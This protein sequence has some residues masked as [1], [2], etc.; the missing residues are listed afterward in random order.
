MT[1]RKLYGDIVSLAIDASTTHKI[2]IAHQ[3]NCIP[4]MGAGLALQIA[5][6]FP[7]VERE[8][9]LKHDGWRLGD[10]QIVTTHYYP[11]ICVA[12]LAGQRG[13]KS[14]TNPVPTNLKA[15]S[16]ALEGLSQWRSSDEATG[17]KLLF[18]IG[19]GCGH[20][21]E[22]WERV[23]PII[24]ERMQPHHEFCFFVKRDRRRT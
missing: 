8:Y 16:L 20:G 23:Q 17:Y 4:I 12:N 18:P 1:I 21:G 22:S 3:V 14:R 24:E 15:L 5:N 13:V 11:N 6:A 9:R 19:M 2:V 10:L 7:N